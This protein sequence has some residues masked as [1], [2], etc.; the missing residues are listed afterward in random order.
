MLDQ[1][2]VEVVKDAALRLVAALGQYDLA[3]TENVVRWDAALWNEADL[4]IVAGCRANS[5]S[6]LH[7]AIL[8]EVLGLSG[9]SLGGAL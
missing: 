9:Y 7:Q 2:T 1:S 6:E 8:G 5:R 4:A 3:A